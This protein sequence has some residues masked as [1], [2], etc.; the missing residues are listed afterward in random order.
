MLSGTLT[1]TFKTSLEIHFHTFT[2]TWIAKLKKREKWLT[3]QMKQTCKYKVC[4]IKWYTFFQISWSWRTKFLLETKAVFNPIFHYLSPNIG[5]S[6]SWFE[7]CQQTEYWTIN[8][9]H[10]SCWIV[11]L[12]I[13]S[14]SNLWI[15]NNSRN[16]ES[17]NLP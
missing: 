13:W 16:L 10:K 5:K 3:F 4:R 2:T 15:S 1:N 7:N 11:I 12:K 8:A 17:Y 6:G 14:K 9:L